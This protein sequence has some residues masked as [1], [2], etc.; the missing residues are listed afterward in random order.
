M[1]F[2]ASL[3]M[4]LLRKLLTNSSLEITIAHLLYI[5]AFAVSRFLHSGVVQSNLASKCDVR[6][7]KVIK[8]K[9]EGRLCIR[10]N[11]DVACIV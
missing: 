10:V 9:K 5:P 1:S 11:D 3:F 4:R 6:R 8:I 2:R 7:D